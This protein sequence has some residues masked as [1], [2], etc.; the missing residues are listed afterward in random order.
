MNYAKMFSLL[1]LIFCFLALGATQA[2]PTRLQ[3]ASGLEN[4]D[5]IEWS[6]TVS[7][8][9]SMATLLIRPTGTSTKH[10]RMEIH[11]FRNRV[12]I[13]NK[14]I[15][16]PMK[17]RVCFLG[18]A[19]IK[20]KIRFNFQVRVN[21][22]LYKIYL[23]KKLIFS[24]PNSVVPEEIRNVQVYGSARTEILKLLTVAD[25]AQRLNS[26]GCGVAQNAPNAPSYMRTCEQITNRIVNGQI[27]FAGG[28][29]W[30]ASIRRKSQFSNSG[31]PHQC[32]AT[33]INSCWAISA[34]HCFPVTHSTALKRLVL[35]VGDYF[36]DDNDQESNRQFGGVEATQDL[37]ISKVYKHE[38]YQSVPTARYDIALIKLSNC[39]T[40]GPFVRPA[41]LPTSNDQFAVGS[42]CIISGW[43][44]SEWSQNQDQMPKCLMYGNVNIEEESSC[45]NTF[46][47][48]QYNN[49]IMMCGLGTVME[50]GSE[51]ETKSVDACQ[52]DSGGPLVCGND[53]HTLFGITSW[54]VKC[55][56]KKYP[57]VY[58]RLSSFMKWI[59]LKIHLTPNDDQLR[60]SISRKEVAR[61]YCQ[62]K[63]TRS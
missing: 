36:N 4:D 53:V 45:A 33:L 16:L 11:G 62:H 34:G 29:P 1:Q 22:R 49:N 10:F 25:F 21:T 27:A 3:F 40:T 14:P 12:L 43:G 42:T 32:G 23:N 26:E 28:I 48:K 59:Y 57:G 15:S 6:G 52:G 61:E 2:V 17:Y 55:G 8:K 19:L 31:N 18:K 50:G 54:G 20:P 46:A 51:S 56:D 30:Q 41:C 58:T 47:D 7:P 38:M 5:I 9:K 35:R 63:K 60:R 44:A 37:A 24:L 39:A 13:Q